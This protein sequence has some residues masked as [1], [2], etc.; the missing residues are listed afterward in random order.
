[1][2]QK[3][4]AGQ[5]AGRARGA[6]LVAAGD[7]ACRGQRA[8]G[9][10]RRRRRVDPGG[11]RRVRGGGHGQRADQTLARRALRRNAGVAGA[12]TRRP[13]TADGARLGARAFGNDP[14]GGPAGGWRPGALAGA[15]RGNA[16]PGGTAGGGALL[17]R[18]RHGR[19]A[20]GGGVGAARAAGIRR[21]DVAEVCTGGTPV[22]K[23][24]AAAAVFR[25]RVGLLLRRCALHPHDFPGGGAACAEPIFAGRERRPGRVRGRGAG[26]RGAC[27][28]RHRDAQT[29][30]PA[31]GQ[32][33]PAASGQ[34][35]D[36]VAQGQRKRPRRAAV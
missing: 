22:A 12:G 13:L 29:A 20:P 5:R 16:R 8:G 31:R 27:A 4:A 2:G 36:G 1:M 23:R 35:P 10:D 26:H 18:Q 33:G 32:R 7:R 25:V 28:D 34:G 24:R 11:V 19:A 15:E 14:A 3:P 21:G 30:V 6:A 17:F 9:A